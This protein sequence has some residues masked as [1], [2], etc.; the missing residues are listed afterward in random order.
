LSGRSGDGDDR[1]RFNRLWTASP[2]GFAHTFCASISRVRNRAI[3]YLP[4][5][6]A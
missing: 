6:P 5:V 4:I 1:S 2:S 3:R